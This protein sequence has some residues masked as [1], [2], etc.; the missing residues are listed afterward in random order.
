LTATPG[1]VGIDT[2]QPVAAQLRHR[3]IEATVKALQT[4]LCEWWYAVRIDHGPRSIGSKR[5]IDR[6]IFHEKKVSENP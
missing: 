1:G 5:F 3:R 2:I 4:A 6:K